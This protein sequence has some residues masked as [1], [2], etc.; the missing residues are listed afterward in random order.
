MSIIYMY[1]HVFQNIVKIKFTTL[2]MLWST[3]SEPAIL[4]VR[5][6]WCTFVFIKKSTGHYVCDHI[7]RC[8]HL[9][10]IDKSRPAGMLTK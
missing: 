10:C 6:N 7:K 9:H 3:Q 2:Y 4:P 8:T 1:I 5:I